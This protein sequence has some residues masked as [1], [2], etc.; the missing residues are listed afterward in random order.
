MS[1]SCNFHWRKSPRASDDT[2]VIYAISMFSMALGRSFVLPLAAIDEHT[3]KPCTLG[4]V[5]KPATG[6]LPD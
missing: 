4:D 3:L 5:Q 2:I 1:N 6:L